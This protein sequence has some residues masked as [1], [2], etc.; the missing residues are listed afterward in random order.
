MKP[1]LWSR[2]TL[3]SSVALAGVAVGQARAW[4]NSPL[5]TPV[6]RHSYQCGAQDRPEPELQGQVPK[7]DQRDGNAKKGYNCGLELMGFTPLDKTAD[8]RDSRPNANANMAWSGRC[9]YV[10]GSSANLFNPPVVTSTPKPTKNGP[11]IA[12][13]DVHHPAHPKMVKILRMPGG[14]ATSETINAIT[15]PDGTGVLVVGEYGNDPASYPKPMDIYTYDTRDPNCADLHHIPNPSGPTT[16]A[17]YYWSKNIHNL[18]ITP[19]GNYVY[20]T[21]PIQAID[22]RG[23]WRHAHSPKAASYI[24]YVG[25]LN[26]AITAAQEGVGPQNDIVPVQADPAHP[27]EPDNS[28]EAWATDDKT[29]YIGGQ[30]ASGEIL[31]IAD[32]AAWLASDGAKPATVVSQS[33]GRGHSVRT[34]TINGHHY[35]LHSEESVFGTAYGCVPQ[36]ANPFAGPAQPFLTNIDDPAHPKTVSEMGLEINE[37]QNCPTQ[38]ADGEN[39]SVHY[40]DVDSATNTHFVMASMWNAGIRVFDVRKP[41]KPAE[42]AYF[43]PADVAGPGQATLLDHVWGHIHYDATRGELWFASANGGFFVVRI[44]DQ[45]RH[46][47]GLPA[48]ASAAPAS[49]QVNGVDVG[50]PGT[51]GLEYPRYTLADTATSEQF[52]CTVA[53]YTQRVP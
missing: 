13:I 45:V 9:A 42:V 29:L 51:R 1:T 10:S 30:Q 36:V 34:A 11:G 20:A 47:L 21:I 35:L 23:M 24:T 26:D 22:L 32:D 2:A 3:A 25:D 14:V 50:W 6:V 5:T 4:D 37:P 52:Y 38:I 7:A 12:V 31:T 39:D 43:N 33:A 49:H 16:L 40:H 17:T 8:G 53:P 41:A 44:E 28:H 46:Q 19:D 18:T 15:K 27:V 48:V